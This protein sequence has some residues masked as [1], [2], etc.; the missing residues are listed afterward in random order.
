MSVSHTEARFDRTRS[1]VYGVLAAVF[2]GDIEALR[3]GQK[4]GVFD[5]LAEVLPG[6]ERP[7]VAGDDLDTH[8]LS[9]GYDNLFV[10]P[11]PHYV[12]PFASAHR[13][14]P[15]REFE[16]DSP[17]HE[18]G[19]AG[20]LYGDPARKMATLYER[21]GFS[22]SVGEGIPDHLAAELAFL[23]VL[24]RAKADIR[25]GTASVEV[26]IE[27]VSDIEGDMLAHLQ[28]IDQFSDA[29]AAKDGTGVFADLAAFTS[30]LIEWDLSAHAVTDSSGY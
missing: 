26:D 3:T 30:R 25:S 19:Q 2:D 6:D 12:P 23:A 13:D 8:A 29:L 9:L 5:R 28:W 11:G 1:Q 17:H 7:Q 14:R 16:S 18:E 4:T 22:P 27:E 24:A 15:S 20:E 21:V 10:V